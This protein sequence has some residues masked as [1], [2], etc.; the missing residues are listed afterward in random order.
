MGMWKSA[1]GGGWSGKGRGGGG[2]LRDRLFLKIVSASY[3]KCY[4]L[5][6]LCSFL[7]HHDTMH[8]TA[9]DSVHDTQRM[10]QCMTHSA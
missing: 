8:D 1:G 10:T 5:Y 3:L 9:L 6:A 7:Q 4:F 2:I